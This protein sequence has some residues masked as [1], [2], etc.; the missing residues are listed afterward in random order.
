MSNTTHV[1]RKPREIVFNIDYHSQDD[2]ETYRGTF[3]VKRPNVKDQMKIA[4]RK[5]ELLGG[6][7]YDPE[8]P[9]VGVPDYV[10]GMADISA[11]LDMCVVSG[12]SWWTDDEI[13][14]PGLL[15]AIYEEASKADPFRRVQE[16]VGS[17]EPRRDSDQESGG[18]GSNDAV[19]SILDENV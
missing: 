18:A 10:D 1:S 16:P 15:T 5:S 9:G 8:N 11:F 6:S 2:G 4:S 7:Y 17:R 3:T 13:Y 12:P 14:D 19:A